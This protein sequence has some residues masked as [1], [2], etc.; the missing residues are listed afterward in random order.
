MYYSAET[1]EGVSMPIGTD[2]PRY[3]S[4]LPSDAAATAAG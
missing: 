1:G 4:W 3:A 2:H